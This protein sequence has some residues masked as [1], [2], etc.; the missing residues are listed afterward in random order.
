MS[1]FTELYGSTA[2]RDTY[3]VSGMP[4]PLFVAVAHALK[5]VLASDGTIH[6][7]EHNAYLETCRRYGASEKLLDELKAWDPAGTTLDDCFKGIDPELIPSRL[8]LYDVIRIA[9]ADGDYDRAERAAVSEAARMLD[10]DGDTLDRITALV[11]MEDALANLRL[12][13]LT[14]PLLRMSM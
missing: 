13:L 7:A 3:G 9:K 14:P 12:L 8:L 4:G 6:P 10:V 11:D 1:T 5:V 2:L